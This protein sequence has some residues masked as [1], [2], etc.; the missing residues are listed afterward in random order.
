M[1]TRNVSLCNYDIII[2]TQT[3][4]FDNVIDAE[5]GLCP[6]YTIF[7]C[8]RCSTRDVIIRGGGVLIA[9]KSQLSYRRI[10]ILDYSVLFIFPPL[11]VYPN[12]FAL[13]SATKHIRTD[14]FNRFQSLC[15]KT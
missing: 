12:I 14:I 5:L 9:V 7:R 3:W 13:I 6:L 2:I 4:L 11:A 8:D 1:F 10:P 15:Q